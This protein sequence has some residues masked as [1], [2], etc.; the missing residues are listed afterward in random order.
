M[1]T[2]ILYAPNGQ[3]VAFELTGDEKLR[4]LLLVSFGLLSG[5]MLQSGEAKALG[6]RYGVDEG[7]YMNI[8]CSEIVKL[9]G[10]PAVK[11]RFPGLKL[12]MAPSPA[13]KEKLKRAF[14][15]QDNP[16]TDADRAFPGPRLVDIK[17]PDL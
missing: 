13:E 9:L 14:D 6:E 4:E 1:P 12:Q 2:P 15:A 11:E 17:E 5:I 3:P 16:L 8:V 10:E 7:G